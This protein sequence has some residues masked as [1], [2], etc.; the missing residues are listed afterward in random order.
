MF[1]ESYHAPPKY[2]YPYQEQQQIS[3][4]SAPKPKETSDQ[5]AKFS[6]QQN[7]DLKNALAGENA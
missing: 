5:S 7:N 4:S 2:D 6:E 1:V 3:G